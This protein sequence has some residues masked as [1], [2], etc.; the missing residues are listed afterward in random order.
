MENCTEEALQLCGKSLTVSQVMDVV[1]QD[2]AFYDYS[3]GGVTLSG[4]E[5][6]IQADFCVALLQKL[7]ENNINTAVDTSGYVPRKVLSK[8][9]PYT[10]LFL[11]DIK[12]IDPEKHKYY[13]GVDN[14][15]IIENLKYLNEQKKLVEIRIPIIPTVNDDDKTI[16]DIGNL[17]SKQ[18]CI[19]SVR[20]L[21]YN[22]LAS[23]KYEMIGRNSTQPKVTPLDDSKMRSI[24]S[25]LELYGL[26]VVY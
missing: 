2:K 7:K 21:A 18:S 15:Q 12:H 4:G 24:Q 8:V 22:N 13:T 26:N 10:D 25:T 6:L 19:Q 11:Y 3:G 14:A 16:N 20:I 5:C 1:L 23:S 9:I 17:L